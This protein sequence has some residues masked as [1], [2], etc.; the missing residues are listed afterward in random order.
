MYHDEERQYKGVEYD[1]APVDLI[2]VREEDIKYFDIVHEL[3][4]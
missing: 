4:A 3:D 1:Y 2:K